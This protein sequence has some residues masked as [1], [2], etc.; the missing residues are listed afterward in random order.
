MANTFTEIRYC[1]IYCVF[2]IQSLFLSSQWTK[3]TK[4]ILPVTSVVFI[5]L[6]PCQII[7]RTE[8]FISFESNITILEECF[9]AT[10][11]VPL[12]IDFSL[13]QTDGTNNVLVFL[14]SYQIAFVNTVRLKLETLCSWVFINLSI[15]IMYRNQLYQEWYLQSRMCFLSG[16]KLLQWTAS[17]FINPSKTILWNCTRPRLKA[18]L[19]GTILSHATSLQHNYYTF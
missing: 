17:L 9:Q 19:H 16:C 14:F 5:H 8:E 12:R 18:D 4:R 10:I 15:I 1:Y 11:V 2:W 3:E 13:K 7:Y 6:I